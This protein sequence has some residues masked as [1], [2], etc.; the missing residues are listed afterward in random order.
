[1]E[2]VTVVC[3]REKRNTPRVTDVE[4]KSL[5]FLKLVN[6]SGDLVLEFAFKM[7]NLACADI[8]ID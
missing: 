4:L 5:T 1:M 6:S 3:R 8:D 7:T 2:T